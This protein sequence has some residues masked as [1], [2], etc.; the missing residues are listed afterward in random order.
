VAGT[1]HAAPKI[2]FLIWLSINRVG[3]VGIE[4]NISMGCKSAC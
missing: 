4:P 3:A 1:Y 2:G